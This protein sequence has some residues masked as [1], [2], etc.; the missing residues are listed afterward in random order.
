MVFG[1]QDS[2]EIRPIIGQC[3]AHITVALAKWEKN[4]RTERFLSGFAATVLATT[5][6]GAALAQQAGELLGA[7]VDKKMGFQPAATELARDLQGLDH[8]LLWITGL[9]TLFVCALLVWVMIRY[10]RRANP[11]PQSF[12]H[13]TTV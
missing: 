7:P 2:N 8:L 6:S 12:T 4:M 13:N 11:E 1:G 10:N 9:I 5:V 3:G